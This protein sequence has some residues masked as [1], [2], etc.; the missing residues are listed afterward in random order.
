MP[1]PIILGLIGL[2]VAVIC[3]TAVDNGLISELSF[4]AVS[5][6]HAVRHPPVKGSVPPSIG[7]DRSLTLHATRQLTT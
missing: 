6:G 4:T 1:A 5:F 7:H 3:V 2:K